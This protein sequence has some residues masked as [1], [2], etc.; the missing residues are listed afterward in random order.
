MFSR[1]SKQ[2]D[3]SGRHN[4]TFWKALLRDKHAQEWRTDND[5]FTSHGTCRWYNHNGH[6]LSR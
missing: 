1:Y 4:A 6:I 5:A 2:E 3:H